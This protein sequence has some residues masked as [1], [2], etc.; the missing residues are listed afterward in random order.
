MNKLVSLSPTQFCRTAEHFM[1]QSRM[2]PASLA[3]RQLR[4]PTIL[5]ANDDF[6][7]T[8]APDPGA[9]APAGFQMKR[10][11]WTRLSLEPEHLIDR[12]V[13]CLQ[14]MDARYELSPNTADDDDLF[15]VNV[16][17]RS[18][19]CRILVSR[20]P[21]E[22]GA[23]RILC[24]RLGGDTFAYHDF[25]KELRSLLGDAV[26]GG[27]PAGPGGSRVIGSIRPSMAPRPIMPP[28]APGRMTAEEVVSRFVEVPA[29]SE[30]P[31]AA[32]SSAAS[33]SSAAADA[34]FSCP[35]PAAAATASCAAAEAAPAPAA[36]AAPRSAIPLVAAACP[37]ASSGGNQSAAC[38]MDTGC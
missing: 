25:F 32:R 9:A 7:L 30:A 22:R 1:Q 36:T 11:G 21:T 35:L 5:E 3:Q 2:S 23:Y 26:D 34:T 14:T 12:V 24:S 17:V 33:S 27:S 31:V 38:P 37:T 10:L 4:Q 29:P 6:V 28:R 8:V 18:V 19:A 15:I 13:D 20:D 16:E